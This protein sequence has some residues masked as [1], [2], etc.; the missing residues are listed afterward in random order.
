[1][2]KAR[3]IMTE[4]PIIVDISSN[5]TDIAR[6]LEAEDIGAVIVCNSDRRLQGMITDR[7]LAVGVIAAGRDPAT[8]TA[9]DLVSGREVVTIGADDSIEEAIQTMKTHAVRRLPVI[10]GDD[11]VGIISQADLAT[12]SGETQVGSLVEQISAAPDNTGRG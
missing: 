3:D 5:V 8:T 2:A 6:Q 12:H 4:S 10:D 11:V 9:Q 7:D 1:M